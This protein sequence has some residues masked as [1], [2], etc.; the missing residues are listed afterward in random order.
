M[1]DKL[2]FSDS[3]Q[4]FTLVE[5]IVATTVIV[6]G[7][8]ATV[9][10]ANFSVRA[11][12]NNERTIVATNLAREGIEL[13]R[14]IRDTNWQIS[15]DD[16][17]LIAADPAYQGKRT[18]INLN[19]DC[20]PSL[21][22]G[23]ISLSTCPSEHLSTDFTPVAGVLQARVGFVPAPT[24]GNY[25]S[26]YLSEV[27]GMD[28]AATKNASYKLCRQSQSPQVYVPEFQAAG[29]CQAT[30]KTYYRRMTIESRTGDRGS[31][32]I[33]VRSAV[34]WDERKQED[35]VIEEYLTNWRAL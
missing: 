6:V 28:A 32:N 25:D 30:S 5:V 17:R 18:P 29:G 4:G 35:I 23:A 21:P 16:Q 9:S 10:V 27:L 22:A 14:N 24:S 7:V 15:I 13:V 20:F 34:T 2:R 33:Y 1:L 31:K 12:G 3:E 26:P 8:L 19:W 11:S